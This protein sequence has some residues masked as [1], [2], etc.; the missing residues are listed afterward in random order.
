MSPV[1][2][3]LSG[4]RPPVAEWLVPCCAWDSPGRH[5]VRRARPELYVNTVPTYRRHLPV[6]ASGKTAAAAS[7]S[8]AAHWKIRQQVD[9]VAAKTGRR[10][11]RRAF[12]DFLVGARS[13]ACWLSFV[14][15]LR[16][17]TRH[18]LA[19]HSFL[20]L[21]MVSC[22]TDGVLLDIS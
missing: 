21:V 6:P 3:G 13:A 7:Q 15:R 11:Y 18:K 22:D 1:Y 19:R 10:L 2:L 20:C 16:P 12:G 9:S 14:D 17:G 4:R 8:E 5:K